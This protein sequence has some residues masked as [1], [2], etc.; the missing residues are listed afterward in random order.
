MRGRFERITV[1]GGTPWAL[2][3]LLGWRGMLAL[4]A[5]VSLAVA[6]ALVMGAVFLLVFPVALAAG[7]LARWLGGRGRDPLDAV[8]LRVERVE[9]TIE[10]EPERVEILPPRR[11]R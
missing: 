11:L 10:V 3:R 1:V 8:D 6:L 5:G 2:L 4:A 9:R 7:V